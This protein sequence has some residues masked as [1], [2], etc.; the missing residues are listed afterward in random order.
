MHFSINICEKACPLVPP[1]LLCAV[2]TSEVLAFHKY[3]IFN[4]TVIIFE[5][6]LTFIKRL[7][8]ATQ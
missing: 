8:S 7:L 6:L 2:K 5:C 3:L 1:G 4:V